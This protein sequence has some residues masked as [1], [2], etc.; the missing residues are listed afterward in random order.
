L[1][2]DIVLG[3]LTLIVSNGAIYLKNHSDH[4][5]EMSELRRQEK[6]DRE[7][8][9]KNYSDSLFQAYEKQI[10]TFQEL[11]QKQIDGLQN[12]IKNQDKQMEQQQKELQELKRAFEQMKQSY[13]ER[14][15]EKEDVINDLEKEL[16]KK[17]G[18]IEELE[19]DLEYYRKEQEHGTNNE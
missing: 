2:W 19:S 3:I 6:R 9:N 12:H 4:R 8:I 15:E 1:N 13:E 18:R 16:A 10:A 14:L 5:K 17:D 11:N 7:E